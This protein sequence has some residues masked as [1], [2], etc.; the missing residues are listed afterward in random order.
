MRWI[1][2]PLARIAALLR[3]HGATE[4]DL[5]EAMRVHLEMEIEENLRRGMSA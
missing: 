1:R 5:R 2:R 3:G 4:A